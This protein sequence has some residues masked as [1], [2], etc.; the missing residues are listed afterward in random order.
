MTA[1]FHSL[2]VVRSALGLSL[3]VAAVWTVGCRS[4]ESQPT[5]PVPQAAQPMG[6]D[7]DSSM[8]MAGHDAAAG[9]EVPEGLAEL[10]P[11]DR[12]LAIEQQVC[13]VSGEKLGSMGPPIKVTVAGHEVFICCSGCKQ[14]LED[15]PAKYLAKLALEP[16][17]K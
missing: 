9:D 1:F 12:E 8:N 4:E 11:A 17:A 16:A 3:A 6:H 15:D 10:S 2:F 14:Q 5:V 7:H 13:P